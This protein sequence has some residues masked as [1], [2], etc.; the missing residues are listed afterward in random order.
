MEVKTY[1]YCNATRSWYNNANTFQN[2]FLQEKC[3]EKTNSSCVSFLRA[4]IWPSVLE[5]CRQ[6]YLNSDHVRVRVSIFVSYKVGLYHH[7]TMILCLLSVLLDENHR[8]SL[9]EI[10]D[11]VRTSATSCSFLPFLD[12]SPTN[13]KPL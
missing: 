6:V 1:Q 5:R 2:P 7:W 3:N 11:K 10:I 12:R 9:F 8:F 4:S 13:Q